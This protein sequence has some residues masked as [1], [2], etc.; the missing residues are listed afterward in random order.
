MNRAACSAPSSQSASSRIWIVFI[1]RPIENHAPSLADICSGRDSQ[2]GHFIRRHHPAPRL[3]AAVGSGA[4]HARARGGRVRPGRGVVCRRGGA[5]R[6]GGGQRIHHQA[7]Q[8]AAGAAA[9]RS[10][11]APAVRPG[12]RP[13]PPRGVHQPGLGGDRQRRGLC[14]N[15]LSRRRSRRRHRGGPGRR[16]PGGG[17]GGGRGS[18]DRPGGAQAGGQAGRAAGRDLRRQARAAGGRRGAGHRQPL[19]RGPDHY[20]GHRVGAG[21]QWPGYQYL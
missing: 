2:S 1:T 11:A 8:R 12:A 21:A 10:R 13:E 17:Q 18:G 7:C 15:Q 9:R 19:R 3:A 4:G 6:A 5:R 16:A 14:A 20:A